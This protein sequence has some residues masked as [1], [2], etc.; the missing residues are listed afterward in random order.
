M[1]PVLTPVPP[2]TFKTE[3]EFK[4]WR[5]DFG[6]L[7][8]QYPVGPVL[9]LDVCHLQY[10]CGI[11]S[12]PSYILLQIYKPPSPL[13]FTCTS[14]LKGRLYPHPYDPQFYF[15]DF[16]DDS[17][18]RRDVTNLH[19]YPYQYHGRDYGE[20]EP[21]CGR[22]LDVYILLPRL[23]YEIRDPKQQKLKSFSFAC[24]DR[25]TVKPILHN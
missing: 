4:Q 10:A 9:N 15:L 16:I 1:S 21:I 6:A 14:D 3:A 19:V 20:L 17:G 24:E 12:I 23:S 8:A 11:P 2:L 25:K 13:E 18:T 22:G 7:T 5:A